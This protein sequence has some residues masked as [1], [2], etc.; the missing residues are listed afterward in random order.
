MTLPTGL[1]V[2][3]GTECLQVHAHCQN[4]VLEQVLRMLKTLDANYVFEV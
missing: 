1:R 4:I 2:W 3:R